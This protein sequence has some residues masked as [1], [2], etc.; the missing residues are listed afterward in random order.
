MDRVTLRRRGVE[1]PRRCLIYPM[2]PGAFQPPKPDNRICC[3]T[4]W[5]VSRVHL[6]MHGK[7]ACMAAENVDVGAGHSKMLAGP[8]GQKAPGSIG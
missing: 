6:F 2:L 4:H 3:D 5:M 7:R 1:G 8:G